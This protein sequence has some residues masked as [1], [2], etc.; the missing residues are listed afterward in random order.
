M[1]LKTGKQEAVGVSLLLRE[2][3]SISQVA[4]HL[5]LTLSSLCDW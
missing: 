1:A 3:K 5:D 4:K 2:V